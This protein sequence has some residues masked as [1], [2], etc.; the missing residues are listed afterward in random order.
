MIF[1]LFRHITLLLLL[2][3]TAERATAQ[4]TADTIRAADKDAEG[5]VTGSSS[6]KYTLYKNLDRHTLESHRYLF[7]RALPPDSADLA[8]RNKRHFWRALAETTGSN[9]TLW[10]FDRFVEKG[11]YSYISWKTIKNN[12]RNGFEWDDDYLPTNMFAHPYNGSIF[13]NAGR[14]NGFNFWQS[15]LFA[16]GGSAMWELFMENEPPSTNDIIATPVGG[17]AIG[18]VFYR[19]SD[20]II[21][22]RATGK[23]RVGR[24]I[25]AFIVDPMRG[26]NRIVTGEA[27]RHRATSGQHFGLPPIF[28][29]ISFGTRGLANYSRGC[30]AVRGG[31]VARL[32]AEYGNP[33][34]ETTRKPYDYFTLLVELQCVKTQPPIG[35]VEIMGRLLSTELYDREDFNLNLGFYQH[36]DFIDSDT[37][38]HDKTKTLLTC[39]IPY[40]LATPASF[41]AGALFRFS[42][43]PSMCLD[44]FI[45]VNAVLLAGILTDYYRNY[46]RSYNYGSG[47]SIKS[48]LKWTLITDRLSFKLENRFYRLYTWK[49]YD[50]AYDWS[51]LP[52]GEPTGLMG[53]ESKA[54][55]NHLEMEFKCRMARHWY[56]TAGLDLFTRE[57]KYLNYTFT[58]LSTT[59]D[60]QPLPVRNPVVDSTQ[61]GFHL[62]LTYRF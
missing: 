38:S 29:E 46:H 19:A 54:S 10:A 12:F 28:A 30:H 31:F 56:L 59:S 1:R 17:T 60:I 36:F 22:D 49:G 8:L 5:I 35:R 34:E 3:T 48:G 16:F 24:E 4:E 2:F 55:F 15:S 41:G 44:G 11:H 23:E 37:I 6:P 20:L 18:E 50:Q 32:T 47:F 52:Y 58:P 53:D 45:H 13:Y 62:L 27:W 7:S 40:K 9:I 25:A 33:Y 26:I 39:P 42:P 43:F 21:D 14:S 57:T 51:D 61:L